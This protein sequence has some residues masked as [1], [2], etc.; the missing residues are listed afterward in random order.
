LIT[1]AYLA[2]LENLCVGTDG[3]IMGSRGAVIVDPETGN[4]SPNLKMV[5]SL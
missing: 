3:G 1:P 4:V 2:S 5:E